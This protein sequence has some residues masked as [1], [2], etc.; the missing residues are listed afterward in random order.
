MK[1][2]VLKSFAP[3]TYFDFKKTLINYKNRINF[4]RV[5]FFALTKIP[6]KMT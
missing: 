5:V 3:K 4:W 2:G 1:V 6:G